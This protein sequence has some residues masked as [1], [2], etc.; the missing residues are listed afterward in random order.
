MVAITMQDRA[1]VLAGKQGTV[2]RILCMDEDRRRQVFEQIQGLTGDVLL[3]DKRLEEELQRI[4]ARSCELIDHAYDSLKD[5]EEPEDVF[6]SLNKL[7]RFL[8]IHIVSASQ[9]AV[10]YVRGNGPRPS[11]GDPNLS[12]VE[13]LENMGGGVT[14]Y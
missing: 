12:L 2:G 6:R 9:N 1:D 5:G 7:S 8:A 13:S 3:S 10:D 11:M 14:E 4:V